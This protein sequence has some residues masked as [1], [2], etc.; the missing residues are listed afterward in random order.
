MLLLCVVAATAVLILDC[1]SVGEVDGPSTCVVTADTATTNAVGVVI[2]YCSIAVTKD[3]C[4]R[5]CGGSIKQQ[6]LS[7]EPFTELAK[8]HPLSVKFGACRL[9]SFSA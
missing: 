8:W 9:N 1:I 3:I 5:L 7:M 2:I 6:Y 4:D